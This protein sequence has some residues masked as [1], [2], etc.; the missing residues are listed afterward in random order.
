MKSLLRLKK[1]RKND[2]IRAI[3][4]ANNHFIRRLCQHVKKL[5]RAKLSSVNRRK[6]QKHRKNLRSLVNKR[7][8]MSKRR[9][10]L[11]QRGGGILD[12]IVSAIPIVGSIYK[13]IKTV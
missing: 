13:I 9:Q 3:S 8:S 6:L 4:M 7:T 5:K 1:L 11:T 10:I 2:R 12:T